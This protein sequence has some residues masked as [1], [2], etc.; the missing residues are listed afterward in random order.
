MP[1]VRRIPRAASPPPP[2]PPNSLARSNGCCRLQRHLLSSGPGIKAPAPPVVNSQ[3]QFRIIEG[4]HAM[5]VFV[6]LC[7][8]AVAAG[9]RQRALYFP[10]PDGVNSP[11]E[12]KEYSKKY[13]KVGSTGALFTEDNQV[14][15]INAMHIGAKLP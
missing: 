2:R 12:C 8:A 3:T 1:F 11:S 15:A 7:L 4:V 13:P 14:S 9:Q 10:V 6:V 5:K